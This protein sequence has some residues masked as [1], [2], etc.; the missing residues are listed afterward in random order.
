[1]TTWTFGGR[2][3]KDFGTITLLNDYLDIAEKRGDDILVPL[4][5][6]RV[7]A[8]KY[9]EQRTIDFGIIVVCESIEILEGV[10][11]DMKLLFGKRT[12]QTL[13]GTF[14]DGTTRAASAEVVGS[15]GISRPRPS[16]ARM[17]VSFRLTD[18]FLRSTTKV[19][20]TQTINAS[21]KNYSL[22]NPGTADERRAIITLTGPLSSTKITNT[23]NGVWVLYNAVITAGHYVIIDC[24]LFTA[25][26]DGV[27]N[28]L[29][30]LYHSGDTSFMVL[31][32][33]D[34]PLSVT[35][36]TATTGTVKIEF[37][38]PYL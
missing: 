21:P 11:D 38:P 1:M 35:D 26:Y 24:G 12:Q 27:T 36:L 14:W 37:Y 3:L 17:T 34:N 18:P 32:P 16:A 9:F 30:A 22:N 13:S 20:D 33:G 19:S 2:Q 25:K 8:V 7:F 5:D 15:L 6:G 10:L 4:V 31:L 28:V 23:A 29:S